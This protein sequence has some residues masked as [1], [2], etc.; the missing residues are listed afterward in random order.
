MK[1]FQKDVEALPPV[2]PQVPPRAAGALDL[3]G[4]AAAHTGTS[5]KYLI[6]IKLKWGQ[7]LTGFDD[8]G[9]V[10]KT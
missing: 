8:F 7:Y 4:A 6:L 9:V 10:G 5:C 3:G 2:A 1:R